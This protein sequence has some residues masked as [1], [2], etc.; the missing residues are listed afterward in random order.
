MSVAFFF[1]NWM[2][3][4]KIM[5]LSNRNNLCDWRNRSLEYSSSFLLNHKKYLLALNSYTSKCLFLHHIQMRCKVTA[6]IRLFGKF[7][8]QLCQVL[9]QIDPVQR[10][11]NHV[12][13]VFLLVIFFFIKT[14]IGTQ[15]SG[16]FWK[17]IWQKNY[18]RQ[19]GK[20]RFFQILREINL[21]HFEASKTVIL[22]IWAALNLEFLRKFHTSKY[23]QNS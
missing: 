2:L 7:A 12:R 20:L 3:L 21:C 5:Y 10:I 22:T 19:S 15:K 18:Y 14:S 1:W 8:N 6:E 4:Q 13:I 11:W 9:S 23:Y 16:Q 17:I